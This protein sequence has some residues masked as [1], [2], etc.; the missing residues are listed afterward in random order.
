MLD[1]LQ[2]I[3]A[4][5]TTD[6]ISEV[7]LYKVHREARRLRVLRLLFSLGLRQIGDAVTQNIMNEQS[8]SEFS[9]EEVERVVEARFERTQLRD[10]ILKMIAKKLQ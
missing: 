6:S 1:Q 9:Y 5:F 2:Q 10:S 4:L 3:P 8:I 7:S